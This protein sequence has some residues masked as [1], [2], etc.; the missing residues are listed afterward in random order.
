MKKIYTPLI[1]AAVCL[2]V[3]CIRLTNEE[4]SS[5]SLQVNLS[6]PEG[7]G[8]EI[9]L[10]DVEVRLQNKSASFVYTAHPDASGHVRFDVQPG[11]YDLMA[12]VHYKI[13][14]VSANAS[15]NEFLLTSEGIVQEDGS[16]KPALLALEMNVV[17]PG[18]PLIIKEIY[19]HGSSTL[20]GANYTKDRYLS[21]YN[22][23]GEGGEDVYLD[24]LCISTIFPYNSTTGDNPWYGRD[25][26]PIA[27]MFWMIPGTGKEHCLH[28]GEGVTIAMIAAVDHSARAV[29]GL[30]LNRVKFGCYAES[31]PGHEIAAGVTPLVCYMCG[32]GNTWAFSIHSPATVIFRPEMG[33]DAYWKDSMKWERYQPGQTTGTKYYHIPKS[34]IIDGVE[35][36][37]KPEGAVKRL[38]SSIDVS[39]VYMNSSH[40]SGKCITRIPD[41]ESSTPSV[42]VYKDTNNSGEDFEHDTP[43]NPYYCR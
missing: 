10:T 39:Y 13:T 14:R 34:W 12:S 8:V 20:D 23:A 32:Q 3:S 27:Q 25:T 35:A 7:T 28:P 15:L 33:V 43:L 11:K 2:T 41:E 4:P 24:S 9:D 6:V 1:V 18:A 17:P 29:S 31:L 37:D 38:P 21:L 42:T 19:Y 22:N 36:V 30:Q 40:Y 26:I 5:A 16:V